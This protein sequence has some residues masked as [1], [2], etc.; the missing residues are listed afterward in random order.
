VLRLCE[1][2]T[3]DGVRLQHNEGV[4]VFVNAWCG[5]L[6]KDPARGKYSKR[7]VSGEI[8]RFL[9]IEIR[10]EG[11]TNL[12]HS[13][14]LPSDRPLTRAALEVNSPIERRLPAEA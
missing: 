6:A 13:A 1:I 2:G 3:L 7:S 8:R 10:P 12:T 11:A 9:V 5:L 4:V 14:A